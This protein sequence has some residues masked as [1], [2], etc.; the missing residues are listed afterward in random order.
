M[1]AWIRALFKKATGSAPQAQ[2]NIQ[3]GSQQTPEEAVR[4]KAYYLWEADGKP[5]GKADYYWTKASEIL[6]SEG[7]R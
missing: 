6:M 4:Q 7:Q 3:N 1:F 5:E 2:G